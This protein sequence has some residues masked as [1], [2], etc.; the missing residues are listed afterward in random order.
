VSGKL[1][2]GVDPG[3]RVTGYGLLRAAGRELSLVEAGVIRT[4]DSESL[5]ERLRTIHREFG[6]VLMELNPDVIALEEL[7]SH[8]K[9]PSTAILMGHARGVIVLWCALEGK[10]LLTYSPT[11]VKSAVVGN[12]HA[13][14]EQVQRMVQASLGLSA[15]PEPPDIA[16]ALALALCHANEISHPASA[17]R[18]RRAR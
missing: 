10:R 15:V 12:G 4:D 16:D 7:Y 14:K 17:A 3:L 13:S 11:R 2:L 1:I 9:H 8:Y 18:G 5:G 6:D